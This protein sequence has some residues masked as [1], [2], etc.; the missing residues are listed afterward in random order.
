MTM[1]TITAIRNQASQGLLSDTA[2]LSGPADR[3]SPT[4]SNDIAV[5]DDPMLGKILKGRG[6]RA[7]D[8]PRM[9]KERTKSNAGELKCETCGKGYKHGSCL[10]KHL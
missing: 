10:T 7:S 6:R 8:A 3:R 2:R 5:E 9:T 1:T 4:S